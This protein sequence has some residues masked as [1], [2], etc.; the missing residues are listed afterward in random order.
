MQISGIVENSMTSSS[1]DH[2]S[3]ASLPS[4]PKQA[5]MDD[6]FVKTLEQFSKQQSSRALNNAEQGIP[7]QHGNFRTAL[8]RPDLKGVTFFVIYELLNNY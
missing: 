6:D 3:S 1:S 8:K 5:L 2:D 4:P 7:P